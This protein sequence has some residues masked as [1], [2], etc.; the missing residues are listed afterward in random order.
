MQPIRSDNTVAGTPPIASKQAARAAKV[1]SARWL[2]AKDTNRHRLQA[3]TAQNTYNGPI[4][5]QSMTNMSPGAHTPG[6]R[7]RCASR[8]HSALAVGD[9]TAEVPAP[10]PHTRPCGPPATTAWPRSDPPS[11]PPARP[12]R[13]PHRHSYAPAR[14][15]DPDQ[16]PRRRLGLG[17]PPPAS[18]SWASCRRSRRSPAR[19][20]TSR[21]TAL[22]SIRSLTDFIE[23]SLRS[24]RCWFGTATVTGRRDTQVD[25]QPGVG[26]FAGHQRGLS[27][28]TSGDLTWPPVGTFSWPW[29]GAKGSGAR[30]LAD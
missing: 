9:Q 20:P 29:T 14:P 10:S 27:M 28:A 12:P 8:R 4:S 21:N 23:L 15:P 13:R 17:R 22:M 7:P 1:V 18:P 24:V 3:N 30:S 2:S 6:R 5:P 11:W 26:T 19:L 25:G 16:R